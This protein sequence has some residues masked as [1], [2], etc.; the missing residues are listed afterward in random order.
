LLKGHLY[1]WSVSK[2]MKDIEQLI[3]AER[4]IGVELLTNKHKEVTDYYCRLYDIFYTRFN[5]NNQFE[6]NLSKY[7]ALRQ[8]NI[9]IKEYLEK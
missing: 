7:F 5:T 2:T 6:S 1:L 3:D 9:L 4:K 8:T